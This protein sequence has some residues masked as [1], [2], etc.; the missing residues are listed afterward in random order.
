LGLK[1][2]EN[3][4]Q[5]FPSGILRAWNENQLAF[6]VSGMST[7]GVE[8]IYIVAIIVG[9]LRKIHVAFW[10]QILTA[11]YVQQTRDIVELFS[12]S[13]ALFRGVHRAKL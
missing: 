10:Q 3:H 4:H 9:G 5:D 12:S 2:K 1:K 8:T 7:K 6:I 13:F 11:N